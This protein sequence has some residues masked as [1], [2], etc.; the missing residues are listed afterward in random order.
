MQSRGCFPERWETRLPRS[1]SRSLHKRNCV[2]GTA[3]VQHA[4]QAGCWTIRITRA[5]QIFGDC[6]YPKSWFRVIT[7][8]YGVGGV[9]WRWRKQCAIDLI[10][11]TG[12]RSAL[13]TKNSWPRRRAERLER[14]DKI[15]TNLIIDKLLAKA[16]HADIPDFVAG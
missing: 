3:L 10:F 2:L 4:A 5:R 15:M 6:R 7:R 14:G 8:K 11:W 12:Q 1:R 13:R 16:K 9:A